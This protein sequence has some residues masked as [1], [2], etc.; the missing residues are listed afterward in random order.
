MELIEDLEVDEKLDQET[1]VAVLDV[2][3]GLPDAASL[4]GAGQSLVD[5]S[6][7][8]DLSGAPD[9]HESLP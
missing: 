5:A 2:E 7:V 6:F 8:Q 9:G 4:E 3:K 1:E